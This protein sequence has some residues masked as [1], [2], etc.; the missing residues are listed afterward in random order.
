MSPTKTKDQN[1]SHFIV[2]FTRFYREQIQKQQNAYLIGLATL[3]I[4]SLLSVWI[5]KMISQTIDQIGQ[6]SQVTSLVVFLMVAAITTMVIRTIS[7]VYFFNPSRWIQHLLR[8]QIY[9][10]LIKQ[11]KGYF[12]QTTSGSVINLVM[13]DTDSIR[14]LLGYGLLQLF[15]VSFILS[16]ALWQMLGINLML[17]L[18]CLIPLIIA[19]MVLR[20]CILNIFELSKKSIEQTAVFNQTIL[21]HLTVV[22]AIQ[23]FNAYE[24][25]DQSFNLEN[26]KLRDIQM[27][28]QT[29]IIWGYP[30]VSIVGGI[31]VVFVMYYGG[32]LVAKQ[33]MTIGQL[34]AFIVY[35]NLLSNALTSLGWFSSAIQRGMLSLMRIQD[36]LDTP[37]DR[38]IYLSPTNQETH[39]ANLKANIHIKVDKLSFAY[40][41]AP[42]LLIL[43]EI[44]FE[45]Q[46]GKKLGIFGQ[47][48]A[49]KTTLLELLVRNYELEPNSKSSDSNVAQNI[50]LNGSPIQSDPIE[51]Y[52]RKVI[53][54]K[55]KP[56]LFSETI[57][58]NICIRKLPENQAQQDRLDQI[59]KETCLD[60]EIERFS[61][62]LK[63]LVGEK[64]ISLSGGQK[65][66]IALARA[67]YL[68]DFE[69]LL[70]DDVLSAVDHA[71][72]RKLIDSIDQRKCT[73]IIVSHRMSVLQ[74]MDH[75]IVL[76]QG[77][78]IEQGT[79]QT[80]IKQNGLYAQAWQTQQGD[81]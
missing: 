34:A 74:K 36:F 16:L 81:E 77:Q 44:S 24:G 22:P 50:Y 40:P 8:M 23:A 21:D 18:L 14:A 75:I 54:V 79:H 58:E 76:D 13:N 3:A 1:L 78:I 42:E 51:T 10:H 68:E 63:T 25:V 41:T 27:K 71:T 31:C 46:K 53:L 39:Q 57:L 45:I 55:Q 64:G 7:R 11:P 70:L 47:T 49:G 56:F 38:P 69:V 67:L 15:N 66:R 6:K 32:S 19:S 30:I 37:V 80:L 5:P 4:T 20:K 35:I 73:S 59:I 29:I 65:Q 43:K 28:I 12:D 60:K 61:D 62:G 48:G 17:S 9:E 72:E 52:A 26:Q 33:E 2:S